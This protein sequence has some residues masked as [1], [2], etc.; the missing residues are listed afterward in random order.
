MRHD[1]LADGH[2]LI[3]SLIS[4]TSFIMFFRH[5]NGSRT[6]IIV[7]ED[8]VTIIRNGRVAKREP[9]RLTD[10][11]NANAKSRNLTPDT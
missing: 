2:R 6:R 4:D 8:L 5:A 7:G 1:F 9:L 10:Y 11:G 3:S